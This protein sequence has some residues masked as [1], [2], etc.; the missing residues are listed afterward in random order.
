MKNTG[1]AAAEPTSTPT[2]TSNKRNS[3][4]AHFELSSWPCASGA[5]ALSAPG[6]PEGISAAHAV[7]CLAVIDGVSEANLLPLRVSAKPFLSA[8]WPEFTRTL[9]LDARGHEQRPRVSLSMSRL[10]LL[11]ALSADPHLSVFSAHPESTVSPNC[12]LCPDRGRLKQSNYNICPCDRLETSGFLLP[13]PQQPRT[14]IEGLLARLASSG[15]ADW[16]N[17][18]RGEM[19]FGRLKD[20]L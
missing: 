2:I 20:I 1:T 16:E 8:G 14:V 3:P 7:P 19:G 6:C 17:R 11:L 10:S 5:C 13:P 4:R 15:P 18:K 9:L 12:V